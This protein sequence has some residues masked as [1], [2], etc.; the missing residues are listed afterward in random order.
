MKNSRFAPNEEFILGFSNFHSTF[1]ILHSSFHHIV[2]LFRTSMDD[3]FLFCD[4]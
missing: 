4:K 2:G 3:V 1:L